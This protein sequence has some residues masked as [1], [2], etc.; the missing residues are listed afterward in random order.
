MQLGLPHREY[1]F[2][3][4][5]PAPTPPHN[6]RGRTADAVS[7]ATQTKGGKHIQNN[8]K[9]KKGGGIA[10]RDDADASRRQR[11]LRPFTEV[12]MRWLHS[13]RDS[14]PY[15][16]LKNQAFLKAQAQTQVANNLEK[17]VVLSESLP[18][19]PPRRAETNT[20]NL[21]REEE[22]EET[23]RKEMVSLCP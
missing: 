6:I 16:H 7:N 22:E 8:K 18:V 19:T 4:T 9:K 23:H 1:K 12:K 13:T 2:S 10:S 14:Q 17:V 21:I 20:A 15:M 5:V 3:L 11:N